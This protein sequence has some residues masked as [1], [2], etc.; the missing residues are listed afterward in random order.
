MPLV[1]VTLGA[2]AIEKHFTLDRNAPGPDHRMSMDPGELRQ[3]VDA[4]RSVEAA[5]GDGRKRVT[6]FEDESRRL[7]RRSIVAAV[8][9]RAQEIIE[10]WMITYKRPG[11]GLPPRE[12]ARIVGMRARRDIPKDTLLSWDDVVAAGPACRPDFAGLA[13]CR[14]RTN[15]AGCQLRGGDT[16][17]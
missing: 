8:D 4:I 13:L 7:G 17:V 3:L 16:H 2:C 9:L 15:N 12:A 14:E 6:P 10:P 5:L 1:A 11:M